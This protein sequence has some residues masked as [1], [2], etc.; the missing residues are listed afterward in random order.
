[1]ADT[2]INGQGAGVLPVRVLT[3]VAS[4]N[5]RGELEAVSKALGSDKRLAILDL[6]GSRTCSVIE[7]AEALDLPFTTAAQH[8]NIL[9]K[10]GLIKTDLLPSKR[11]LKK[12]CSRVFDQVIVQLPLERQK[13]EDLVEIC[14]PIGAYSR[15]QVG[16]TCGLVG[17][18]GIIGQL[19]DPASFFEPE[20]IYTQLLWFHKGYVE[21][22]FPKRFPPNSTPMAIE[23]SFEVCSEAPLHHLDWPSDISLWINGC[24]VGTWTSPA[25]FGGARGALTPAWWDTENTQYGLLKI[26]KVTPT[27]SFIDGVSISECRLQGLKLEE[28]D[29]IQVRV[30]VKDGARNVGGINLFGRKF[31]NYPQ[32]LVMKQ[33]FRLGEGQ[34]EK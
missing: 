11:G 24:E 29:T 9:E 15:A 21:Y 2:L 6:L 23:V 28:S 33:H 34:G 16:P 13:T 5:N 31:G 32:D 25:D 12:V 30:G 10:A 3:L 17:E 18:I 1:M 19:D 26:W 27:G 22:I 20:H 4:K 14:M 7:I 8:V